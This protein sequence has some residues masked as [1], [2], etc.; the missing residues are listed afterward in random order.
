MPR[1]MRRSS[2]RSEG[3]SLAENIFWTD[4]QLN[5]KSVQVFYAFTFPLLARD[6]AILTQP[7]GVSPGNSSHHNNFKPRMGQQASLPPAILPPTREL[8]NPEPSA[9]FP[10]AYAIG[11]ST[12][13]PYGA[14]ENPPF[15]GLAHTSTGLSMSRGE[16]R[17]YTQRK[18]VC[19]TLLSYVCYGFPLSRE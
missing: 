15:G 12:A 3:W 19:E 8:T 5:C 4:L 9:P 11:L 16:V 13:A 2:E 6:G 7:S 14:W 1:N 17:R 10:K 18:L